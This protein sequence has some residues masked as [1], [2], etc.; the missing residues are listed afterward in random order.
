MGGVLVVSMGHFEA[1]HW[2]DEKKQKLR[3]VS[4]KKIPAR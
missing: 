2:C 1:C 4:I 3:W